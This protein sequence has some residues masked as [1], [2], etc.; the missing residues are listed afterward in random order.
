MMAKRENSPRRRPPTRQPRTRLLVVCGARRTEPLYLAGLCRT[1]RNSSTVVKVVTHPRD[2][3]SVVTYAAKKRDQAKDDY[4][5]IWCVLDVDEFDFTQALVRAERERINLAVSNPCFELWLI[6]HHFDVS[7]RLPDAK[8]ALERLK[9]AVPG[10]DK[11]A[12]RFED[13]AV[14]IHD[15]VRRARELSSSKGKGPNPSTGM[16]RLVKLVIAPEST[17]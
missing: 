6:L 2:P 5:Q 16:G 9:A 13:F 1:T 10:Y 15:A 17:R 3:L 11:T 4:G 7:T 12:L 14:G 8:A